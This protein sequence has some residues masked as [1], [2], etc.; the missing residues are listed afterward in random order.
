MIL[1]VLPGTVGALGPDAVAELLD[2]RI[3]GPAD[4]TVNIWG[5]GLCADGIHGVLYRACIAA[6]IHG[7]GIACSF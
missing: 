2:Q 4:F 7:G 3:H 1:V 6:V 5:A